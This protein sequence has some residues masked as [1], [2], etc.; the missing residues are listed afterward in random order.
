MT[1]GAVLPKK[2]KRMKNTQLVAMSFAAVILIGTLLLC[3]P[4]S[5]AAGEWSDPIDC[6]FTATSATCVTGLVVYDTPTHW[7]LFG[8]IVLLI[9]I[10]IGGIGFMTLITAVSFFVHRQI[11]LHERRML[12]DS[13]GALHLG[14][15]GGVFSQILI[16][17]FCI[18]AIGVALLSLRFYP[19]YGEIG[20]WYAVFHSVS[21]FCN[22]G[23]DLVGAGGVSLTAFQSDPLVSGTMMFLIIMGGLGFLVWNDLL[24]TGL[25]WKKMKL[26]TK[27]VLAISG[28]LILIGWGAFLITD[29]NGAF[30]G[31]SFGDKLLASLFQSVTTRTAGFFTVPQDQLSNSGFLMSLVLMFVGGSPGSTAGG[32]KTTTFAVFFLNII[33]LSANRESVVV[34]KR[35][36]HNRMVRQ[37]GAVIGVYLGLILISTFLICL[38]EPTLTLKSV[39]YEV[40]SAMA[41]V[42]LSMGATPTLGVASKLL[43]IFLM[44]AGRLGGMSI[45]LALTRND[46]GAPTERPVEKILIG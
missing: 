4:F 17:T 8:Q 43:L 35:R 6:F 12:Q 9:L 3:L 32:V 25:R 24:H 20:I 42:G 39:L 14:G 2:R 30:A 44:Y 11:N 7:S 5:S 29:Y 26:H 19:M 21:A 33:R 46:D 13:V 31:L 28:A 16:G 45:F 18:E 34:F 41:T 38:L 10:Q 27:M 23:M 36:I 37:A 15:V 1:D 40:V 22:A